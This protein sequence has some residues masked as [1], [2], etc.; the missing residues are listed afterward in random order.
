M[1]TQP[2]TPSSPPTKMRRYYILVSR[3]LLVLYIIDFAVTAPVVVQEKRRAPADMAH[4]PQDAI[5]MFEKRGGDLESLFSVY[6]DYV[7]KPKSST[8]ARPS[9]SSQPSGTGV[10]AP[11]PKPAPSTES[12]DLEGMDAP[13]SA[14]VFPT[15]FHSDNKLL[16][17]PASRPN[18][19]LSNPR[20]STEFDSNHRLSMVK[21][22]SR[23]ASQTEFNADQ[24]YQAAH[25][26]AQFDAVHAYED[27]PD[28]RSMGADSQLGNMAMY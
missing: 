11:T 6:D 10:N 27:M 1:T 28:R 24:E 9:S 3:I 17:V 18:L 21:P 22:P 15:W 12:D 19:G 5:T 13:L 25:P 4:I 23:P 2:S 16:G 26:P 20:P 14:K 8:S 7:A